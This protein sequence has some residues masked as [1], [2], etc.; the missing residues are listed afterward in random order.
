MILL[1]FVI[2]VIEMQVSCNTIING[3]KL[4]EVSVLHERF[5]K[6]GFKKGYKGLQSLEFVGCF[7]GMAVFN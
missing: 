5:Y 2:T 4:P 6:K 7:C 1:I 3:K